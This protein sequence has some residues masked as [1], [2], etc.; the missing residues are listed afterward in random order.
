LAFI[1][2]ARLDL[3]RLGWHPGMQSRTEYSPRNAAYREN[4]PRLT[5]LSWGRGLWLQATTVV[6]GQP[7]DNAGR[8]RALVVTTDFF[9]PI[10]DDPRDR[11]GSPPPAPEPRVCLVDMMY[12]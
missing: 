4:V 3:I 10:V 11:G 9:T 8:S 1:L 5:S 6:S 2:P 7:D 12:V